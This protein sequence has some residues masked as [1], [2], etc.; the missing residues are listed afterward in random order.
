MW[1]G[2]FTQVIDNNGS[3]STIYDPLTT[4]AQGLRTPFAGNIIPQSRFSPFFKTI[5]SITH[6]PTNAVNPFQDFNML[7]FYPTQTDTGTHS[8]LLGSQ[9]G[10]RF[11]SP[12]EGLVGAF[13]TQ[14]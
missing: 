2:D 11:G 14:R 1:N 7:T 10:G 9:A 3:R 5:Q 13:G 12:A 6:L 8:R 4:D